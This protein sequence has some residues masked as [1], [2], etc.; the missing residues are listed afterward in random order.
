MHAIALN[1]GKETSP[2]LQVR[3][4]RRLGN[5]RHPEQQVKYPHVDEQ[6]NLHSNKPSGF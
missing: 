3:G 6:E 5:D 2:V 4:V 1:I